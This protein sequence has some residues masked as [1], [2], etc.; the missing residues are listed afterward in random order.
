MSCMPAHLSGC[1]CSDLAEERQLVGEDGRLAGRVLPN[2]PSTPIRSPRSRPASFQPCSPTCFADHH[3]MRL[4]RSGTCSTSPSRSPLFAQ[5]RLSGP[6]LDIPGNGPCRLRTA[7]NASGTAR[8]GA[9]IFGQVS[10]QFQHLRD[11]LTAVE[12]S[13]PGIEAEDLN[14]V[15]LFG[16]GSFVRVKSSRHGRPTFCAKETKEVHH[17]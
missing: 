7:H 15:Q 11:G 3:L 16:P 13:A 8:P 6:V 14:V 12:T 10:R 9:L 4:D 2:V 5:G 17:G 1:G